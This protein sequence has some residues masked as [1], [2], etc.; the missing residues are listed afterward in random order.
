MGRRR[1]GGR[2][3][4]PRPPNMGALVLKITKPLINKMTPPIVNKVI[5]PPLNR[6]KARLQKEIDKKTVKYKHM[7]NLAAYTAVH[8][9]LLVVTVIIFYNFLQAIII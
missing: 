9:V 8:Y 1:G 4:M 3:R 7:A 6:L 2:P 5:K